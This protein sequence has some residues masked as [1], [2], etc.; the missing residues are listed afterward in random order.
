MKYKANGNID[1]YKTGLVAKGFT[2]MYG[3][4]YYET[5]ALVA[6]LNTVQVLLSIAINNDW[7]F[8]QLDIKK[9]H[10]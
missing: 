1:R 8:H 5:F 2:Q 6:K 10:F 7:P 9:M 3:I 4:D